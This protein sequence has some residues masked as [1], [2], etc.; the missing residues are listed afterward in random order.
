MKTSKQ[1]DGNASE[2]AVEVTCGEQKSC[3]APSARQRD[4]HGKAQTND[5]FLSSG[6]F[7][8]VLRSRRENTSEFVTLFRVL[9]I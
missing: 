5:E 4:W 6:E 2:R 1:L 8:R 9:I 7:G 3:S